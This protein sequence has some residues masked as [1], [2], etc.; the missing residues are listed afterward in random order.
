ML[1]DC[2][3]PVADSQVGKQANLLFF[4]FYL[5]FIFFISWYFYRYIKWAE[6]T[7]IGKVITALQDLMTLY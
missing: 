7:T 3:G 2:E 1:K 4:Y 5:Y 6:L